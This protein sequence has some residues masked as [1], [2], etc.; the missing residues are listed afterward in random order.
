MRTVQNRIFTL[1]IALLTGYF[2]AIVPA[3]SQQNT[4]SVFNSTVDQINCETIRFIHREAGRAEIANNME[5]FSFESILKSIPEDEARTT[6]QVSKDIEAFKTKYKADGDLG[7]QLDNVISYASKKIEA[8]PRK[9]N[10]ADF[11]Q[12]LLNF[13]KDALDNIAGADA[14]SGNA[15]ATTPS[16]GG[17]DEETD[18]ESGIVLTD[19]EETEAPG[20]T[21]WLTYLS[22]LLALLGLGVS[23]Y[24]FT[25]LG[26]LSKEL[27]ANKHAFVEPEGNRPRMPQANESAASIKLLETK[28]QQ[29]I[30]RI[31]R[32]FDD[33]LAAITASTGY[34]QPE[35]YNQKK[36]IEEDE[37]IEFLPTPIDQAD[38]PILTTQERI[39]EPVIEEEEEETPLPVVMEEVVEEDEDEDEIITEDEELAEEED[40]EKE[41][42]IQNTF[43]SDDSSAIPTPVPQPTQ[44]ITSEEEDEE[45]VALPDYKYIGL[46]LHD[47]SFTPQ[48]F[49]DSPTQESLY[50]VEM[51]EDVPNKAF[52]SPLLYPEVIEKAI[53]DPEKYLAPCCMFLNEPAGK[54]LITVIE[55]GRLRRQGERWYIYEK[56]RIRFD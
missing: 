27:Y 5:C 15:A 32:E 17:I 34:T 56:A 53:Q 54:H 18:E 20:D 31:S 42:A 26:K 43:R 41:A 28:M 39:A 25:R 48:S 1:M 36:D 11:K 30:D 52:F 38:A 40:L 47:G 7:A 44:N 21:G 55:E 35:S 8:K 49:T 19:E 3:Y 37:D 10:V 6:A 45:G 51:Y 9:G 4:Q 2:C 14:G 46:P 24:L 33:K 13:K 12:K 22:L 23:A 50:E 29:E 16:T